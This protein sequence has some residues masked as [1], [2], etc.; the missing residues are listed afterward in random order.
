MASKIRAS[1]SA[2]PMGWL[3]PPKPLATVTKSAR[4]PS[5]VCAY[6]S[7]VRPMPHITSS[8]INKIP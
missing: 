1:M 5:A 7:P 2:A 4:A 3:P 6:K 8:R